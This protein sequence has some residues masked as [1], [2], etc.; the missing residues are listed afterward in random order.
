LH[1]FNEHLDKFNI[2]ATWAFA[3]R[4]RLESVL[5]SVESKIEAGLHYE[6]LE[7]G[8]GLDRYALDLP[9]SSSDL[10]LCSLTRMLLAITKKSPGG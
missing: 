5:K 8:R 4:Y 1:S 7:Y 2:A 3:C 6:L 10:A 9:S